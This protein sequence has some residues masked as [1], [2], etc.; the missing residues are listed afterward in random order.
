[1]FYCV[2]AYI[3]P[4]GRIGCAYYD[5]VKCIVYVLEDTQEGAHYDL[6]KMGW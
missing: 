3:C 5:P 2:A 1:M 6:T 4:S